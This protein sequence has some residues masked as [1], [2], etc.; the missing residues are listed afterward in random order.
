[1][2]VGDHVGSDDGEV[3]VL[4]V[5]EGLSEED[6]IDDTVGLLEGIKDDDGDSEGDDDDNND[7]WILGSLETLAYVQCCSFVS[8]QAQINTIAPFSFSSKQ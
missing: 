2:T 4:G 3:E 1:M 6:G 8:S 7:G 5:A